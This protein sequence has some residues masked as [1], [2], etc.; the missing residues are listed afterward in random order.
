MV[1]LDEASLIDSLDNINVS[2]NYNDE[3]AISETFLNGIM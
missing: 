3:R 2:F 1:L